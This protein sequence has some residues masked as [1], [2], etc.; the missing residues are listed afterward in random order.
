MI[1][2][3]HSMVVSVLDA[4]KVSKL[5]MLVVFGWLMQIVLQEVSVIYLYETMRMEEKYNDV[6]KIQQ[7][8]PFQYV[9]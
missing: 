2:L 3:H 4:T 8:T 5:V 7:F 6:E 1:H 9:V